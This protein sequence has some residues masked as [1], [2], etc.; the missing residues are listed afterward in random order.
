MFKRALAAFISSNLLRS[1]TRILTSLNSRRIQ[2]SITTTM[3]SKM[4]SAENRTRFSYIEYLIIE[5]QWIFLFDFQPSATN[6]SGCEGDCE[7]TPRISRLLTLLK[8]EGRSLKPQLKY[9]FHL[10]K[11]FR[12]NSTFKFDTTGFVTATVAPSSMVVTQYWNQVRNLRRE[13]QP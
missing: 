4:P 12:S 9:S 1:F 8:V 5:Y 2:V 11:C 7:D 13:Q 10:K 6:S 3:L